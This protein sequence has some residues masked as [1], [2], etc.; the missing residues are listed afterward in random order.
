MRPGEAVEVAGIRIGGGM[1]YVGRELPSRRHGV[2]ENCLIDPALPV[3]LTNPDRSGESMS[4]WPSY[5]T[6]PPAARGAYLDWLAGGRIDPEIGIGHVFLFFY[7]LERR[8]LVD[9]AGDEADGIVDEVRRL[10]AIY[11]HNGSFRAY[12]GKLLDIAAVGHPRTDRPEIS[13]DLRNGYELPI[14]VRLHLGRRLASGATLDA[15]DSLLWLVSSPDCSLRTAATR[16]FDEFRV[17]WALRFAQR[18][19]SGLAI[20]PPKTPIELVYRAA[21]GSFSVTVVLDGGAIPDVAALS[22]PLDVLRDLAHACTDELDPYSRLLGRRPEARD[23]PEAAFLLPK[24]LL[25]TVGAGGIGT[26]CQWLSSLFD[27]HVLPAPTVLDLLDSLGIEPPPAGRMPSAAATRMGAM[28]D[29]LDIGF[30][31]DR[32]YGPASPAI[33]GRVVLF[34]APDGAPVDGDRSAYQAARTMVEINALAALADG[35]VAATERNALE[36]EL[37]AVPELS[38]TERMRLMANFAALQNDAPGQR[39]VLSRLAKLPD[40]DKRRITQ[41][42]VGAVLADGHSTDG[43]VKFLERLYQAL[44][45]PKEEVYLALHRGGVKIDEPVTVAADERVPGVPIPPASTQA[46]IRI[47]AARLERIRTET[48]AVSS[49]LAGIFVEEPAPPPPAPPPIA[50]T[51]PFPG[52]DV[53]HGELL[54]ALLDVLRMDRA[55]F[56]ESARSRRLLPDG[57]IETINEWGFGAFDEPVLEGDDAVFVV[58]QLRPA[59]RTMKA[60]A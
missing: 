58:D 34:Q 21:S 45:Q 42:A 35:S 19:P 55:A 6:I 8:L 46:G 30:E 7:G 28:L 29:R 23:T 20:R 26:I 48:S 24:D 52:L 39:A 43:E 51:A 11:G 33:D 57:A 2:L 37:A 49:L 5:S 36:A 15:E 50:G 16:C 54:L 3:S 10:L 18:Y 12:A 25:E 1:I 56:E 44:G 9:D 22:A 17:L 38:D 13:P 47:D 14:V 4:Y 41:S 40:Q 32:R 53:P 27:G 59:L 31:P 60:A